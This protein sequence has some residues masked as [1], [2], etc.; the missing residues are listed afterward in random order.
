MRHRAE[1]LIPPGARI[2][3]RCVCAGVP[4]AHVAALACEGLSLG[5][6]QER[7]NCGNTCGLCLPYLKVVMATGLGA[8]PVMSEAQCARVVSMHHRVTETPRPE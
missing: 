7:T 6:I 4:F 5:Q 1:A 8:L 2:V 3:N